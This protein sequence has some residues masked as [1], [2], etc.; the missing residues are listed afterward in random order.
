MPGVSNHVRPSNVPKLELNNTGVGAEAQATQAAPATMA[1]VKTEEVASA[2]ATVMGANPTAGPDGPH[3]QGTTAAEAGT[4]QEAGFG[5]I[6][7]HSQR[8]KSPISAAK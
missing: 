7:R 1:P 5:P 6:R 4:D 2:V 8:R 3:I